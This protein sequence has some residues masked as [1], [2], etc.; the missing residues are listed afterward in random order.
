M[1]TNP[2]A[3]TT[4]RGEYVFADLKARLL[5]GDFPLGHRLGEERL[6]A[7]LE[8]SRTP[9]REALLRL[10][11]EGLVTRHTEG[12]FV[13]TVPDVA[14]MRTLYEV[15]MGLEIQ[16]LRRPANLGS[17]H[18]LARVEQLRAEWRALQDDEP[19]PSPDFVLLD[20]A[21]HLA[22]AD[23][24]GNAVLVEFLRTVN[25]RIRVVR[26]QDFLSADRI[27]ST[28]AQHISI[29]DAVLRGE[30]DL[31]V[32]RFDAHLLESLEVVEQRTLQ[33]IALMVAKEGAQ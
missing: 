33:V 24:A 12:G 15:R 23:S 2:Y 6:A 4:S 17:T 31:A 7:L 9:V 26:M 29:C 10:H 3:E 20:E 25:E 14:T 5:A 16:A 22:L 11:T 28:I 8:V 18:D 19:K 32:E 27:G 21:F 13:P 1:Y 30:A